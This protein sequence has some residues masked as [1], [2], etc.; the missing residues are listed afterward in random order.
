[1]RLRDADI[2]VD[3]I[4]HVEHV[5]NRRKGEP[6]DGEQHL[7][8]VYNVSDRWVGRVD[9]RGGHFRVPGRID[10]ARLRPDHPLVYPSRRKRV[11]IGGVEPITAVYGRRRGRRLARRRPYR[12]WARTLT[13]CHPSREKAGVETDHDDAFYR[14]RHG[15]GEAPRPCFR[16]TG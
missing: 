13:G 10:R 2:G 12:Q 5:D 8:V 4:E 14:W 11:G 3:L 9:D 6:Y 1:M 7:D 15:G 16:G